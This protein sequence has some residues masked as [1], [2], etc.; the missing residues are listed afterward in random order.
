MTLTDE[1][2]RANLRLLRQARS[3]I[4]SLDGRLYA[5]PLP[6]LSLSGV[7]SHL[8]H[9]LDFYASFL[10]GLG[11]G[12]LD[13]DAR[14][15]DA[16]IETD[17]RHA[18]ER[19]DGLIRA[20]EGLGPALGRGQL[21]VRSEA[22]ECAGTPREAAW[23]NSSLERELSFLCSHTVHHFALIGVI[24][25]AHGRDPGAHFGVAPSTLEH[26]KEEAAACAR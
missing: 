11:G 24:L 21:A 12:R 15:R 8:R 5:A 14:E 7:G 2:L 17:A 19:L 25:R 6:A 9:C 20:L 16:R 23:C 3:L 26:W 22:C 13:Y 18:L 4:G 10:A 1:L